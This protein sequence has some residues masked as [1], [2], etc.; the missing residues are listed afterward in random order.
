MIYVRD[1]VGN[2]FAFYDFMG[3]L[4]IEFTMIVVK[5]DGVWLHFPKSNTLS[6]T[7]LK[8]ITYRGKKVFDI[9]GYDYKNKYYEVDSE[10]GY[11]KLSISRD[12]F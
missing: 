4:N 2:E 1:D 7:P 9:I 10:T 3:N 8:N 12:M 6:S 11:G 5:E